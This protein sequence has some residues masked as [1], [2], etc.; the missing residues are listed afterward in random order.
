MTPCLALVW[1]ASDIHTV[2]EATALRE[3]RNVILPR[4]GHEGSQQTK[5]YNGK[6]GKL[7]FCNFYFGIC[8]R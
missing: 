8:D 3:C 4:N 6:D 5:D 1:V 7:H 2:V